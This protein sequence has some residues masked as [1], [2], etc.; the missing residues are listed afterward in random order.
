M[1]NAAEQKRLLFS[2]LIPNTDEA[3][4][5]ARQLKEDSLLILHRDKFDV[6]AKRPC[7]RITDCVGRHCG[8]LSANHDYLIAVDLDNDILW[9]AR[10]VDTMFSFMR[11]VLLYSRN[12]LA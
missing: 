3:L 12:E 8:Y 10:V 4:V 6:D 7:I 11:R 5:Q 1:R 2:A 9:H